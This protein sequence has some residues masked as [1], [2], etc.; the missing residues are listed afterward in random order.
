MIFGFILLL[1]YCNVIKAS[2]VLKLY[3]DTIRTVVNET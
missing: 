1:F 2:N 3:N